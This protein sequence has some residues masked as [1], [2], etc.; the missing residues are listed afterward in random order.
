[1]KFRENETRGKAAGK[2]NKNEQTYMKNTS[3]RVHHTKILGN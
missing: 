2:K 3:I 1:V